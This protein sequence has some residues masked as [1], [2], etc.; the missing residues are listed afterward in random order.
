MSK[1]SV[2]MATGLVK[3]CPYKIIAVQLIP[4]NWEARSWYCMWIQEFVDNGFLD[5]KFRFFFDEA[6]FTLHGT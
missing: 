4:V 2:C 5:P 3:L 6:W 1:S